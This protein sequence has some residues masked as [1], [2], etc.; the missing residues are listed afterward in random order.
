MRSGIDP[1]ATELRD[2]PRIANGLAAPTASR[3][4]CLGRSPGL[5]GGLVLQ[6]APSRAFGTVAYRGLGLAYRCV[7]S[8]G[9]AFAPEMRTGFP[10]HPGGL[11]SPGHLRHAKSLRGRRFPRNTRRCAGP[12]SCARRSGRGPAARRRQSGRSRMCRTFGP[13]LTRVSVSSESLSDST[14][15]G[16]ARPA[17]RSPTRRP[18]HVARSRRVDCQA[19]RA[20]RSVAR[21]R[22]LTSSTDNSSAAYSAQIQRSRR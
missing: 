17:V 9:M 11:K 22:R 8:A 15:R 1:R 12:A 6:T 20:D 19:P 21:M 7:G 14:A 5:R 18:T 2:I 3:P 4:V 13:P 16:W 10:F